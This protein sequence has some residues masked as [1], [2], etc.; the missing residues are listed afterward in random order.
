M[1]SFNFDYLSNDG[2][3]F[4]FVVVDGSVAVLSPS[5]SNC[6]AGSPTGFTFECG[7]RPFS[8]TL[9]TGGTHYVAVGVVDGPNDPTV[10]SA[11]LVDNFSVTALPEPGTWLLLGSALM[12]VVLYRSP[13]SHTGLLL[14]RSLARKSPR[15]G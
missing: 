6:A 7:Y 10:N 8:A 1:L 11:I 14:L 12:G 9:A 5:F 15:L 3:D 13:R 2:E 4:A